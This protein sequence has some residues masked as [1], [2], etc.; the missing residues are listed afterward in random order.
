MKAL[1]E[2]PSKAQEIEYFQ[3]FM[4]SL[5]ADS[6]LRNMFGGMESYVE[7]QIENDFGWNLLEARD[8]KEQ[9]LVKMGKIRD[10]ALAQVQILEARV[11]RT[12]EMNAVIR[13]DVSRIRA[14]YDRVYGELV[15]KTREVD[16]AQEARAA[17]LQG[18][19]SILADI[20]TLRQQIKGA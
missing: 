1:P 5:P 14:E 16:R 8:Q 18:M 17:Y 9:E 6:Y 2:N 19:D 10:D 3:A 20:V 12:E 7:Q 4:K 11:K 15:E 13:E